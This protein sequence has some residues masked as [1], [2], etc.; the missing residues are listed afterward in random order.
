MLNQGLAEQGTS[1][2]KLTSFGLQKCA[3]NIL[4]EIFKPKK[5]YLLSHRLHS[6]LPT[7]PY[8]T[9][10]TR[11]YHFGDP[12]LIDPCQSLLNAIKRTGTRL[13]IQLEEKDFVVYQKETISKSATVLL[14]DLSR[15]MRFENRYIAAKKVSLAI[16]GLVQKRYLQDRIA[17]VEFSTKA[18][19]IKNA[20]IPFL[21]SG[22]SYGFEKSNT[23]T[24]RLL[25][26]D[27]EH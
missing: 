2:L 7:E 6:E 26:S 8:L 24:C 16:Y 20:E 21:T 3:W 25:W 19:K 12:P 23:G 13:P 9:E 4:K 27:D 5:I 22:G 17:V 1:G 15:S 10:G 18:H 14:L 11:P